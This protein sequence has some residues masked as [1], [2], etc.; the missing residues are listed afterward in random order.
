MFRYYLLEGDTAAPSRLYARLCHAFLVFFFFPFEHSER[1]YDAS[2]AH[3]LAVHLIYER[4][5]VTFG[6]MLLLYKAQPDSARLP[7]L[8]VGEHSSLSNG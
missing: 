6:R 4:Q 5:N 2:S 7:V 3:W 1:L 8:Q